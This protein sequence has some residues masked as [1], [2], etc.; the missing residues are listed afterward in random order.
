MEIV[1]ANEDVVKE[2]TIYCGADYILKPQK[3]HYFHVIVNNIVFV[4]NE[5]EVG[6]DNFIRIFKDDNCCC[7]PIYKDEVIGKIIL[8]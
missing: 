6:E 2:S 8:Q 3:R 1:F 4:A 7:G 5:I